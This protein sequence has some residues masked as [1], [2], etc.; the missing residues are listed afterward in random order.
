MAN[1][2]GTGE[3]NHPYQ[4]YT[5]EHLSQIGRPER[6]GKHEQE[7]DKHFKLMV[8]N[9]HLEGLGMNVVSYARE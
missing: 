8:D 3:P 4:I 6:H 1:A 5:A 7:G 2:G 9:V